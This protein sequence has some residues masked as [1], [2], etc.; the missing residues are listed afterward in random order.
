MKVNR[1]KWARAKR[2]RRARRARRK[3]Q[4]RTRKRKLITRHM[5]S[6]VSLVEWKSVDPSD[7]APY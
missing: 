1:A 4:S 3:K 7:E 5:T 6:T 2:A